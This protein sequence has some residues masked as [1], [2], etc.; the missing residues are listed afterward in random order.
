MD[1]T[2]LRNFISVVTV[3]NLTIASQVIHV[4]PSTLSKQLR[5]LETYYGTKL[6][7]TERGSRRILLTETGRLLY[8]KAKYICSLNDLTK[9]DIHR[10]KFGAM[11]TLHLSVDN[12]QCRPLVERMLKEFANVYPDICF[13]IHE[14][15]SV[16]LQKQLLN[17]IGEIGLLNMPPDWNSD[18]EELFRT[19]EYFAAVFNKQSKWLKEPRR[20]SICLKQLKDMPLSVA[21]GYYDHFKQCCDKAGF[22]PSVKCVSTTCSSALYWAGADTAVTVISISKNEKLEENLIVKKITDAEANIYKSVVK[23]KGRPLSLPALKF[24]KFY[25]EFGYG[26]QLCNLDDLYKESGRTN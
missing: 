15:S 5:H 11:G 9:E 1:L 16:E 20:K 18:F 13:A 22:T 24:L 14:A 7:L 26:K 23:M 19:T 4:A 12:S 21:A 8:E 2:M 10:F 17:G 25:S 6:I 3:G